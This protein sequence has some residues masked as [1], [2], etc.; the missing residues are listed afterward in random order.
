[1]GECVLG[2][3][4]EKHRGGGVDVWWYV[5]VVMMTRRGNDEERWAGQVLRS[6][7]VRFRL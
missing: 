5:V 2:F 4:V 1:M 6:R 3:V 7:L